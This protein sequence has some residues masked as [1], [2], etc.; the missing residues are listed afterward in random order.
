MLEPVRMY[1]RDIAI[2]YIKTTDVKMSAVSSLMYKNIR[3]RCTNIVHSK[4]MYF[5]RKNDTL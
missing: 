2:Y 5:S 3:M 1:V 4:K